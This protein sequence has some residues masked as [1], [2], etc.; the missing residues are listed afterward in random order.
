MK[1]FIPFIVGILI[2]PG[3]SSATTCAIANHAAQSGTEAVGQTTFPRAAQQ[4]TVSQT[5]T[6]GDIG[7]SVQ[8]SGS[9]TI[10]LFYVI[11][12]NNGGQPSDVA[13]G[14]TGTIP[15]V[16][17][18]CAVATSTMTTSITLNTSTTYWA[19]ASSSVPLSGTNFYRMCLSNTTSPYGADSFFQIG[20]GW[21]V[22][23]GFSVQYLEIDAAATPAASPAIIQSLI[24]WW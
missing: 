3:I 13:L 24:W 14:Q 9:P 1:R 15:G 4:F 5:C 23:T 8:T 21:Q 16:T 6:P 11:E 2:L 10:N 20:A 12:A 19:V 7:M 17:S 22:E 18:S